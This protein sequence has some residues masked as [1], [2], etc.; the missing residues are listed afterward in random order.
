MGQHYHHL[1]ASERNFI[2]SHLNVKRSCR[3]IA[4][5]LGRSVAS[6][7]REVRR[8]RSEAGAYDAVSAATDA[9]A[10]RRRGPVKLRDGSALR[11]HVFRQIR[12]GWSPQ[13]ISGRLKQMPECEQV[14]H[15]TIYQAIY[16][17]PRGE[18]RKEIIGLLRQGRKLRRQ[19]SQGKDRR[20]GLIGM[21]SIHERP[22]HVLTREVF[23]DWEG[24]FIKGAANASAIGTLVERKSRYTI[25]A[26]MKNCGADAALSGFEKG[27]NRVPSFMCSTLTYDQGKEM[28]R[29]E[30][31]AK[32][33]KI[34]VYF[35][36]PH[37][38]WQRPSNENMNGLI[39]QYLPKGIDLSIYSQSD[40]NKIAQSLNTRPRACLGFQT[41]EEVFNKEAQ[42]PR[43]ALQI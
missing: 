28:A 26:K 22:E 31:L 36:D 42:K 15:E 12:K 10:R 30:E 5:A 41:P 18:L 43:V 7:S 8:S 21:V 16:V 24:D 35:C 13:Q 25:L 9:R 23:G 27:L 20:G 32:R 40:L 3:W 4:D 1:S 6:V 2:Q 14:S 39:R 37:S 29:H 17:L 19:R 34:K 33:L 11:G 38:P